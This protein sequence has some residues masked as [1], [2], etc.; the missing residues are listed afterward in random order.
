[1]SSVRAWLLARAHRR[2]LVLIAIACLIAMASS[3]VGAAM[4]GTPLWIPL[5]QGLGLFVVVG[6]AFRLVIAFFD[7]TDDDA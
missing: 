5:L 4:A 2:A 7:W 1:M 3:L 6:G